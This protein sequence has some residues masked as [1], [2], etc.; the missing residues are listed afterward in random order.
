VNH[1]LQS[2][3][4][5]TAFAVKYTR[6]EA[7]TGSAASILMLMK[8]SS[9]TGGRSALD[10]VASVKET[11]AAN[12]DA[13]GPAFDNHYNAA[14]YTNT[15]PRPFPL[16]L[17]L[18]EDSTSLNTLHCY[19]RSHLLEIIISDTASST[20]TGGGLARVGLR[21][22]HCARIPH[23]DR[24][25]H[26]TRARMATFFPKCLEDLYRQVCRWQGLHFQTCPYIPVRVVDEY[27][28]LKESDKTRGNT[29]Y[30]VHSA[31]R[32]GLVNMVDDRTMGIRFATPYPCGT[33]PSSS[34]SSH[35]ERQS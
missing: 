11:A 35:G 32:L 16:R 19:V 14:E 3:A 12:A 23:K 28:Q 9:S 27:N 29:Q 18:P 20:G 5:A 10:T 2:D 13:D 15:P 26:Q 4:Q 33:L 25:H 1:N 6:D 30:W 31:E 24:A 17:A 34:E 8:L 7:I 22:V 21:C